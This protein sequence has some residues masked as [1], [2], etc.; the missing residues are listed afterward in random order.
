VFGEGVAGLVALKITAPSP[1]S[2]SFSRRVSGMGAGD[3]A[4]ADAGPGE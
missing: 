3:G 1:H 4:R 2:G